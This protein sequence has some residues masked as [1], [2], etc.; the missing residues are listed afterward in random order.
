LEITENNLSISELFEM[1]HHLADLISLKIYS[2]SLPQSRDFTD[3]EE[4]DLYL[5]SEISKVTKINLEEMNDIEEVY[6][7]MDLCSR[8]N[9][10]Q[11][12]SIGIMDMF[13][14]L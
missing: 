13:N 3:E 12:D 4:G 10:L 1:M 9:Y 11:V 7:L 2:L 6:F 14:Y 8:M 5:I